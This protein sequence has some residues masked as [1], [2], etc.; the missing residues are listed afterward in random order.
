[1]NSG[2]LTGTSFC[3]PHLSLQVIRFLHFCG[4]TRVVKEKNTDGEPQFPG[5]ETKNNRKVKNIKYGGF[6]DI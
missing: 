1:M 5:E 4:I 2:F 6:L 3:E